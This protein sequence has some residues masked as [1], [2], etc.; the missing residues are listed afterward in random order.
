MNAPYANHDRTS[1]PYARGQRSSAIGLV[2]NLLLG[3]GKLVAGILGHSQA[4][5]ADAVESL[6]DSVG[7]LVVWRGLQVASRPPDADHP[8]GH[9][10]A[11]PIAAAAVAILLIAAGVWIAVE[12][13]HQIVVPH[14]SPA[15]FTL[16]VV[17]GVV[18]IKEALFRFVAKVGRETGSHA[19][20]TDAWHHRSDAITSGAA[21]IGIAIALVGG[22]G[23][24]AAD[25]WAALFASGIIILSGWRLLRPAVQELMDTSP[26]KPLVEEARRVAE[27]R[28]GVYKVEKLLMRKM[29]I[30]YVADMH[31]EVAPE[32][33][34]RESHALAHSVKEDVQRHLPQIV[35]VT[36][37]VEPA[38]DLSG[39]RPAPP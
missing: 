32:M 22:R 2:V 14:Q 13:V 8:Y 5:V 1:D 16:A 36:I 3:A 38:W 11:E 19:V 28:S 17:L 30:Y 20:H 10:K 24:E 34:V 12:S 27:A 6:G 31:L 21:A 33:S 29:G 25:D 23:F 7:S 15:P 9:G 26:A 35:E 37:H 39:G 4:L 18:V